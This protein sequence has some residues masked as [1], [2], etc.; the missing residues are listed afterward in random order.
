M[1]TKKEMRRVMSWA[2]ALA[3]Q[4]RP[5]SILQGHLSTVCA[6]ILGDVSRRNWLFH[7]VDGQGLPTESSYQQNRLQQKSTG[8]AEA[9]LS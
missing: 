6:V 9:S 1:T 8:P 5:S 4:K 7:H 3:A 2:Y